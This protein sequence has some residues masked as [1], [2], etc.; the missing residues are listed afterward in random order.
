MP[1]QIWNPQFSLCLSFVLLLTLLE[2][3]EAALPVLAPGQPLHL[4]QEGNE[5]FAPEATL[6][7]LGRKGLIPV[8]KR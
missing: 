7:Q 2:K 8:F 4:S 5:I 1:T 6:L 3:A